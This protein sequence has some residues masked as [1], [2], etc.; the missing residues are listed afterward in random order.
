MSIEWPH[1]EG[2][3]LLA[4][5]SSPGLGKTPTLKTVIQLQ[6]VQWFNNIQC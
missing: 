4:D 5:G 2:A 1:G 6:G 3:D